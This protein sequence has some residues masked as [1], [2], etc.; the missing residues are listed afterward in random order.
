MSAD[1]ALQGF[2]QRLGHRFKDEGLLRQALTHASATKNNLDN[3][4]LEFLGDRVLGLV[5][6]QALFEADPGAREGVLAPRLNA[7]VRKEA[8]AEVA[9]Q[10]N[11]GEALKL[12]R[13]EMRS[14]GR[15]KTALLGDAMEAVIAAVYLDSGFESAQ[16]MILRLWGQRIHTAESRAADPKSSLQEWAQARALPTPE[17]TDIS[18][19]GPDH[20]PVFVV[21]VSVSSGQKARGQAPAKKAAQ[22]LAAAAL[23]AQLKE[24]P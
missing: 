6:A 11:L 24:K 10:I 14:G 23:M 8:C 21:E 13:S 15:R 19:T 20:Q 4:R 22:V 17:Y 3:Q 12:G 2:A 1:P 16:K 18:R 9:E 7:L 5:I